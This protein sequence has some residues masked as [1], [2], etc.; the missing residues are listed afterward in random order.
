MEEEIKS[1]FWKEFFA[2]DPD[3]NYIKGKEEKRTGKILS[4]NK[5]V[6]LVGADVY[7]EEAYRRY[8]KSFE[9]KNDDLPF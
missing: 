8:K 4:R 6:K 3:W 2:T 7:T 9:E 5:F 1:T